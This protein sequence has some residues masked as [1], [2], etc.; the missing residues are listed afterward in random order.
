MPNADSI[1]L[2]QE[3][4]LTNF[5]LG[6]ST[7]LPTDTTPA[8]ISAD[9]MQ[10]MAE[11]KGEGRSRTLSASM[12]MRMSS[13]LVV[14][15]CMTRSGDR[16]EGQEIACYTGSSA[17]SADALPGVY[18]S[19][20]QCRASLARAH[21]VA[22]SHKRTTYSATAG[23]S[24]LAP[25]HLP[26]SGGRTIP[27]SLAPLLPSFGQASR[28]AW[29]RES[30]RDAPRVPVVIHGRVIL[31]AGVTHLQSVVFKPRTIQG[32]RAD[33]DVARP[34][35]FP[36]SLVPRRK[37]L[38][39]AAI[40]LAEIALALRVLWGPRMLREWSISIPPVVPRHSWAS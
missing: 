22:Q 21:K 24:T 18:D 13:H 9:D 29:C 34:L 7:P 12:R 20:Q 2:S 19:I 23:V 30:R 11:G 33:D 16:A 31:H 25:A 4:S 8:D 35:P 5:F 6:A 28:L 1:H 15:A 3:V 37:G 39:A 17:V 14:R 26:A 36:S 32:V 38:Y 27:V 10:R 40:F